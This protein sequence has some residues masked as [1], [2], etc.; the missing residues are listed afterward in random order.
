MFMRLYIPTP[1]IG[2]YAADMYDAESIGHGHHTADWVSTG[3][4]SNRAPVFS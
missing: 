4:V 3:R 1:I 2:M